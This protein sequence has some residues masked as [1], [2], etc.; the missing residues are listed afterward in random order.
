MSPVA[1]VRVVHVT[2]VDMSVRFLLLNQLRFLQRA[3]YAVSAMC[4]RGQWVPEIQAAGIAVHPVNLTRRVVDPFRDLRALAQMTRYLR[5]NRITLVHTHTPKAGFLGQLAA[6]LAGVP[7]IVNT[8]HGFYF[9]AGT[10]PV[11]RRLWIALETIAAHFSD[12]ILSQNAEDLATA[13][14]E[15]ICAPTK[16]TYLGNGIDLTRFDRATLDAAALVAKRQELGLPADAPVVG[17]VGRLVREKGYMEF[18]AAARA[19]REQFP[20]CQFIVVGPIETEKADA[21]TPATADAFGLRGAIHFL[22]WR[23]DM[24]AL[25]ALMDVLAL[26][27]YR[28]GFPRA[29]MEAA[30]MGTPVVATDIRGC[31]EVVAP[32]V[33]GALVPPRDAEALARA[34][35]ELL[36]DEPKR[37]MMGWAGRQRAE[38]LFD[39]RRVFDQVAAT[40][41][42]LLAQ[43]GIAVE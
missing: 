10:P 43:K 13:V 6:R 4:A 25:Y 34:L 11:M 23:Q 12:A 26:P 29:P 39:E 19:I 38:T 14:R 1:P 2:T 30:A 31:R 16:I 9:H 37:R 32:G 21:L 20:D 41:R 7:V 28:E 8:I 5:A 15:K 3:G 22:G 35:I 27:S 33:N 18:F 17:M 42:R 40:Y 36:R 24:P